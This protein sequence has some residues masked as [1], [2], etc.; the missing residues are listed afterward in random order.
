MDVHTAQA[1]AQIGVGITGPLAQY[2]ALIAEEQLRRAAEEEEARRRLELA[3][4]EALLRHQYEL[5]LLQQRLALEEA[6]EIAKWER[7][8]LKEQAKEERRLERV[9]KFAEQYHAPLSAIVGKERA[10]ALVGLLQVS[11]EET[12]DDI[13][14]VITE[15]MKAEKELE[16]RQTAGEFHMYHHVPTKKESH[17][18]IHHYSHKVGKPELKKMKE[19]DKHFWSVQLWRQAVTEYRGVINKAARMSPDKARRY[20]WENVPKY[21]PDFAQRRLYTHGWRQYQTTRRWGEH[22]GMFRR[23]IDR[24]TGREYP[25]RPREVRREP[26]REPRREVRRVRPKPPPPAEEARRILRELR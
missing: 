16:K 1:L 4:R 14:K 10:D 24:I 18:F 3:E 8:M 17:V 25:P 22:R 2:Q 21:L 11:P 26:R 13:I 5:E 9:R 7:E 19:A 12:A 15:H 20:L 6:R 23:M